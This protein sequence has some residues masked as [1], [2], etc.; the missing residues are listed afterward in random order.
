MTVDHQQVAIELERLA[1]TIQNV[2]FIAVVTVDGL[3]VASHTEV[4]GLGAD[5]ISAMAAAMASLGERIVYELGAGQYNYAVC[6]VFRQPMRG[7]LIRRG[8]GN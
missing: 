7:A 2:T 5:K 8:I 4:D 1:R 6:Q 3:H